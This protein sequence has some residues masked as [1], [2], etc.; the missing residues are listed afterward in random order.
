MK[1]P[2]IT[3]VMLVDTRLSPPKSGVRGYGYS[4]AVCR[5][6]AAIC[7]GKPMMDILLTLKI[8]R[9]D[10]AMLSSTRIKV[11]GWESVWGLVNTQ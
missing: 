6:L 5:F 8:P 1:S 11:D 9:V 3:A 10:A 4:D 7:V 2:R